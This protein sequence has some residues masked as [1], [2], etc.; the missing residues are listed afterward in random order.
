MAQGNYTVSPTAGRDDIE[1]DLVNSPTDP[2]PADEQD[3]IFEIGAVLESIRSIYYVEDRKSFAN[4]FEQLLSLAQ[5]GLVG[6][7]AEPD[8]AKKVLEYIKIEVTNREGGKVK[9]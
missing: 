3:L 8:L 2:L 7:H 6:P 4:Y 9:N 5:L 1:F